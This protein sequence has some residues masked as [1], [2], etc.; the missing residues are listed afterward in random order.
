MSRVACVFAVFGLLGF[1]QVAPADDLPPGALVRLG[2]NR[3]RAGSSIEQLVIAPDGKQFATI[4][5][6]DLGFG[7]LT[8]WDATTGQPISEH[9]LNHLDNPSSLFQGFTW[10][11]TGGFAI[12]RRIEPIT[13]E[14]ARVFADDFRVWE[15]TN[16]KAKAPPV[17]PRIGGLGGAPD[18]NGT[19]AKTRYTDFR[20][21]GDGRRVAATWK[22]DDDKFG[23]HVFELKAADSVANLKRVGVI[24]LG[25]EGADTV[26]LSGSGETLIA[27][28]TLKPAEPNG[29]PEESVATVWDVAT[30]KPERP[31]RVPHSYDPIVTPDCRELLT[32]FYTEKEH[33]Y[34]IVDLQTGKQRKLI[35]WQSSVRDRG[36]VLP[37]SPSSRAFNCGIY[38]HGSERSVAVFNLATGQELGFLG[39]HAALVSVATVSADGSR[40]VTADTSGLIRLWDA[41]TLRPLRDAP[42]HRAPVQ[43]AQLSPDGKRVLTWSGDETVRLWDLVTGK[44]LRAFADAPGVWSTGHLYPNEPTCTP[45]GTTVL[46]ST[47]DRLI[48][49]DLQTG[50][51]VPLPGD[52][53]KLGPRLV[54]FAPDGEMVLTQDRKTHSCEVWDWP[55][56]RKRF[57]WKVDDRNSFNPGFSTDGSVIFRTPTSPIRIDAKTGKELLPAWKSEKRSHLI[58]LLALRPTPRWV[59]Q[60][61]YD[62]GETRIIEAGTSKHVPQFSFSQAQDGGLPN[63]G[64]HALSP[65]G[66]QF[67]SIWNNQ[68]DDIYLFESATCTKRRVLSG[69]RGEA[70]V[71][72]FTPDGT[73]LLTAG[74][75]HSILV[76]DMRL[77]NV[78]LPD[79]LKKETD[80]V[81]LWNT[82]V[83][84]NAKDA[85]LA[86]SRLARD[87]D[88][89]VK[90][91]KMKLKPATKNDRDTDAT[92]LAD[93][94]AIELLESLDTD[95]SRELLKELADG[96]A[97][98]FRTQEAK[99]A[100][101]RTSRLRNN[102]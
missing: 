101:E 49:R 40:I 69:H 85:Y 87:P 7:A 76:W 35:R 37:F 102:R 1:A 4:R 26:R 93:A 84:G 60:H 34:D 63:D 16:P 9:K 33:G 24:D 95:A 92:K 89:A 44:E 48:A 6:L 36:P 88:A 80:A 32:D 70:R 81:K 65:T 38:S 52:M 28:R 78:P 73:K 100:Q 15:F 53:A 47:K 75:D 20:F 67:A 58:P 94:R 10:N 57:S 72:G 50:L 83:T 56:G 22:S 55:S 5:R 14:D 43:Y 77:Q 66:N 46:Y 13:G 30:G 8:L 27:F 11:E 21:S 45:D 86:M 59:L 41:K 51:E 42:G 64:P 17:F 62:T 74:G 96:Y 90:M 25:A 29:R 98:A 79:A 23:V 12:H 61:R 19:G 99:R 97:D 3:Y 82:L 39:G 68:P 18:V 91:S 71:L 54:A 2:D 31:V